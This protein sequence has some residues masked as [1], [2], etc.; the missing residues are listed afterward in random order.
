[1][2]GAT[3]PGG[4]RGQGCPRSQEDCDLGKPTEPGWAWYVIRT[5]FERYLERFTLSALRL[6][7][8]F[9]FTRNRRSGRLGYFP[10][11]WI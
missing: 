4:V 11:L 3:S 5:S 9:F 1:M 2:S 10:E 6:Q 8:T 7:N